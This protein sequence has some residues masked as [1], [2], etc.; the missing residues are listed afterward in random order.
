MDPTDVNG[1]SGFDS[2]AQSLAAA[3]L[4]VANSSNLN[5]KQFAN[6][7]LFTP[8]STGSGEPQEFMTSPLPSAV[9]PEPTSLLLLGT[10]LLGAV[11]ILR[12]RPVKAYAR[13]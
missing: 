7:Y 9:T 12:R 1:Q 3:A 10:G 4:A 6:D 8:T 2:N 5:T 11:G 13:H